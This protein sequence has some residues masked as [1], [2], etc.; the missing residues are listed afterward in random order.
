ML[1]NSLVKNLMSI[2]FLSIFCSS[3]AVQAHNVLKPNRKSFALVKVVVDVEIEQC[4]KID[5]NKEKC[6]TKKLGSKAALGSGT[7][8]TYKNKPAF[9]SAGHVCLGPAFGIWRDLPNKSK[10]KT[11]IELKS[12]TGH[13]IKA[14]IA[15]VNINHDFCILEASHPSIP[16]ASYPKVSIIQPQKDQRFYSVSA[17]A[18][19]FDV[20]M[21]PV[22]EGRYQGDSNVFSFYTIPTAPGASGGPIYDK[23][24]RIVGV[25]Q[26]TNMVFNNIA[27]SIKHQDMITLL[28]RYHKFK[29][30]KIESIIE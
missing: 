29:A 13:V 8:F 2:L 3:C 20:G 6:E 4:K 10:V 30:E 5:E 1:K 9:M 27:L 28:D 12:Y 15:Y 23:G 7:F 25:I 11:S 26:R 18:A 16:A 14:K 24:N 19:I 17:P 22:I 21:V